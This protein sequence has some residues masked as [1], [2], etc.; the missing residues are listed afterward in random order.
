MW[1][2]RELDMDGEL[3]RVSDDLVTRTLVIPKPL[4]KG[5][6]NIGGYSHQRGY[7]IVILG[8]HYSF[9]AAA[10]GVG[11]TLTSEDDVYVPG[12]S[13]SFTIWKDFSQAASRVT[14]NL[15]P[16]YIPLSCGTYD[17]TPASGAQLKL[18]VTGSPTNSFI[19]IWGIHTQMRP[20]RFAVS[21]SPVD[22]S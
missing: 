15:S 17:P 19:T 9:T 20:S 7:G 13:K 8:I 2:I 11:I 10:A 1:N 18:T 5:P 12:T 6:S 16:I 4:L 3:W 14:N 21:G 22:F